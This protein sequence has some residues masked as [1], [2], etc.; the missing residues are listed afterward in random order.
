MRRFLRWAFGSKSQPDVMVAL[1][2]AD[3]A[4]NVVVP[5]D[6]L[7][8]HDDRIGIQPALRPWLLPLKIAAVIGLLLGKRSPKLGALTAV[9]TTSYFVIATGYHVRAQDSALG[10]A[11]AVIYC[12]ASARSAMT[13]LSSRTVMSR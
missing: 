7:E 11:P 3:L 6:V 5:K 10:T 1:L 4:W 2:L 13:F 9:A 12:G 8:A